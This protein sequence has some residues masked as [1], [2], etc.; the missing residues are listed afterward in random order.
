MQSN[1]WS[2]DLIFK[3]KYPHDLSAAVGRGMEL[4]KLMPETFLERGGGYSTAV[5]QWYQP[6]EWEELKDFYNWLPRQLDIVWHAWGMEY[7]SRM[8]HNSW[9][10]WHPKGAWTE[11]HTHPSVHQAVTCYLQHEEGCGNI[12]YKDPMDTYWWSYP[13]NSERRQLWHSVSVQQNDVLIFPGWLPHKTE[14]NETNK[15]RL[16]LSTNYKHA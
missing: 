6:H 11:E 3:F 15:D 8:I 12:L 7:C 1:P 5:Y 4:C 14:Q 16:V 10:N 2:S 9:I 13:R